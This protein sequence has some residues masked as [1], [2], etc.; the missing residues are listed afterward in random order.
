MNKR[1]DC[2]HFDSKIALDWCQFLQTNSFICK[3]CKYYEK[4][5][6]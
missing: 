6:D 4:E 2:K 3:S 1:G 5:S